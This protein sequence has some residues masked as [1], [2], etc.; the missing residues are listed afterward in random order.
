MRSKA[1]AIKTTTTASS[2]SA[3]VHPVKE[4]SVKL[5]VLKRLGV[6]TQPSPIAKEKKKRAR[7]TSDSEHTNS[8]SEPEGDEADEG[9]FHVEKVVGK[10]IFD[11]KVEYKIRWLGYVKFDDFMDW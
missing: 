1:F 6:K 9:N 10:R 7:P 4:S 3:T 2:T 5:P 11:G 8:A